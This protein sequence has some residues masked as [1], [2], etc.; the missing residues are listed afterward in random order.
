MRKKICDKTSLDYSHSKLR[1]CANILAQGLFGFPGFPV[2]PAFQLFRLSLS[3]FL[4]FWSFPHSPALQRR[5]I[6]N[7][8]RTEH[9]PCL[10]FV[11]DIAN[12]FCCS[13]RKWK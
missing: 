5:E 4:L 13:E 7:A 11:E 6:E 12:L 10:P 2:I 1:K 9:S 3:A 8:K